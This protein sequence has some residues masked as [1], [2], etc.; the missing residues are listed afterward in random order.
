MR[1]KTVSIA[2]AKTHLS[3]LI[4]RVELGERI[5]I[6]RAGKPVV[7]LRPARKRKKRSISLDDPLLRV[8]EY[9]YDGPIG[10]TTNRDID[11]TVC[12]I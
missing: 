8:D 9:S 10:P 12:G 2:D 5:V 11:G 6:T 7:E 4:A 3:R 1:G